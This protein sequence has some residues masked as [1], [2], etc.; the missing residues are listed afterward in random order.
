MYDLISDN[1]FFTAITEPEINWR[2]KMKF[3]DSILKSIQNMYSS[4][5]E[6]IDHANEE[7]TTPEEL[8]NMVNQDQNAVK[9]ED[10]GPQKPLDDADFSEDDELVDENASD[11]AEQD[12]P[13]AESGPSAI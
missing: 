6:P 10:I 12:D 1:C 3:V 5:V 13:G 2:N 7:G 4:N 8:G 11:H 9:F